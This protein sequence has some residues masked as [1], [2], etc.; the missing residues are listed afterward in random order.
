M[1]IVWCFHTCFWSL[2]HLALQASKAFLDSSTI[3]SSWSMS[4]NTRFSSVCY[5]SDRENTFLRL[6]QRL[7][8]PF[9]SGLVYIMYAYLV[10]ELSDEFVPHPRQ[11]CKSS[12][13]TEEERVFFSL[14]PS[15]LLL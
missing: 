1:I 14:G 15:Q 3:F 8:K 2:M 4:L 12:E 5:D 11:F 7:E 9:M 6:H 13:E 10:L